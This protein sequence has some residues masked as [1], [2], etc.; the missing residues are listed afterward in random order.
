[1]AYA[2]L[3]LPFAVACEGALLLFS[4]CALLASITVGDPAAVHVIGRHFNA[5]KV[6]Q[7]DTDVVAAHFAGQ[8]GQNLVTIV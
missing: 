4:G 1:M 2:D 8:V 3:L 7:Q 6:A 5:H